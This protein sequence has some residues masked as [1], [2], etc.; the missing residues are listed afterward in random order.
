MH[1]GLGKGFDHDDLISEHGAIGKIVRI[2][3]PTFVVASK[4]SLEKV[5]LITKD[6]I[7]KRSGDAVPATDLK[8]DDFAVILGTPN[9]AGQIEAK[10]IRL[11]P[12]LPTANISTTTQ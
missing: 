12:S 8:I 9:D 10:F 6:T 5:I 7:I 11:L 3:L 2:N 1:G 4:E